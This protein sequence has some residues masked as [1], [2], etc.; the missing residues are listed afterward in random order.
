MVFFRRKD[1]QQATVGYSAAANAELMRGGANIGVVDDTFDDYGDG[2]KS[3]SYSRNMGNMGN[4]P[5]PHQGELVRNGRMTHSGKVSGAAREIPAPSVASASVGESLAPHDQFDLFIPYRDEVR[6]RTKQPSSPLAKTMHKSTKGAFD[7]TSTASSITC[8]TRDFV[9]SSKKKTKTTRRTTS[10][11]YNKNSQRRLDDIDELNESNGEATPDPPSTGFMT[12]QTTSGVTPPNGQ[13]L[14]RQGFRDSVLSIEDS[15]HK[16]DVEQKKIGRSLAMAKQ[17]QVR[18]RRQRHKVDGDNDESN[19]EQRQER[20]SNLH[21][22]WTMSQQQYMDPGVHSTTM[23]AS[24][25]F[26]E[27]RDSKRHDETNPQD[28]CGM[29]ATAVGPGDIVV[30]RAAGVPAVSTLAA[31]TTATALDLFSFAS[32]CFITDIEGVKERTSVGATT[33][34]MKTAG[35]WP[36]ALV[37]KERSFIHPP[38]VEPANRDGDF[39]V[40]SKF[41]STYSG[42]EMSP[43][44]SSNAQVY[45][46]PDDALVASSGVD[47]GRDDTNNDHHGNEYYVYVNDD[48]GDD[49]DGPVAKA[50]MTER[51]D[52]VAGHEG[53]GLRKSS[54]RQARG[55]NVPTKNRRRRSP[56]PPPPR[57]GSIG[58][59]QSSV[60]GSHHHHSRRSRSRGRGRFT[61][62]LEVDPDLLY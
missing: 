41:F 8:A 47:D 15:M 25:Q 3:W 26:D 36:E 57:Y 62:G 18:F 51:L 50:R 39:V 56:L 38:V 35:P 42:V 21:D 12:A 30:P 54:P 24:Q 2:M 20:Y 13:G 6:P 60:S 34:D 33:D 53:L 10:S 23:T 19:K 4:H 55:R 44:M 22:T 61:Q 27:V 37:S 32:R 16:L 43:D 45:R 28:P 49:D 59:A 40:D 17:Q 46:D 5:F 58:R 48:G 9:V 11:S 7:E 31:T 29:T 14:R 1:D 52:R